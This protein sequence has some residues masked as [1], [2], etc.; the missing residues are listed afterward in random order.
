MFILW[1]CF[2]RRVAYLRY[3]CNDLAKK[4]L[5]WRRSQRALHM[6]VELENS[7]V[8]QLVTTIEGHR[9]F[10]PA[11]LPRAVDLPA[12][13]IM[14][15]DE[16]SRAVATLSGV[17]ETIPNPH[18]LVRPFI[19][20]EAVLSSRIE[21]T[22][23]SLSDLLRY[24]AAATRRRPTG[25]VVEVANYVMALE[26]GL[27]ALDELPICVRLANQMHEILLHDV[28]GED[29]KP[30]TLR[31]VPVW[32]GAEGSPIEAARYVPPPAPLVRE[33]LEDWEQFVNEAGRLPPL[34]QCA[35]MHYQFEAIH[36]YVDGNGRLG[37]LLVTLFLCAKG[38][39][40][41]PLLYLSAYLERRRQEYYDGLLN[42]SV[43]GDWLPWLRY[44]LAG[45]A[46]QARDTLLRIRHVRGL[47]ERYRAKLQ[48][49]R[50]SGNVFR[51]LDELFAAPSMTIPEAA[52]RLGVTT[53]GARNI[54][55]KLREQ[56][57]VQ[58]QA[59]S[60]PRLYEATELLEIIDAP[61]AAQIPQPRLIG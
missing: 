35:M 5:F 50:A 56:D 6:F 3:N 41:D 9:A 30:G 15:L 46:E 60:W 58:L 25:D 52:R 38:V 49:V 7:P 26:H 11:S 8:G 18:L 19:R 54:I 39:L 12:D 31:E 28:R 29:K 32:I 40:R 27:R 55:E 42:V 13:V 47:Q 14:H 53:A 23:A 24:E 2:A 59:G 22:Q 44:F 51:L 33:L 17:G 4:F 61:S 21:G 37:R 57:I 10:V 16:A 36:P 43:T 48:E 1:G 45:V 20:R 34:I